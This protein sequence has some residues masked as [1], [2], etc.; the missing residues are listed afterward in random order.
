MTMTGSIKKELIDPAVR[1]MSSGERNHAVRIPFNLIDMSRN[2]REIADITRTDNPFE[3][4]RRGNVIRRKR[5][6][7]V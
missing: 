6:A 4:K 3:E 5:M 2:I 7:V 1:G